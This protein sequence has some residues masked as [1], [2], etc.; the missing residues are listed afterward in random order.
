MSVHVFDRSKAQEFGLRHMNA[1]ILVT[2]NRVFAHD[3]SL[4]KFAVEHDIPVRLLA[5]LD[6][7]ETRCWQ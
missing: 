3:V 2:G 5:I 4:V 1:L 6:S 7:S